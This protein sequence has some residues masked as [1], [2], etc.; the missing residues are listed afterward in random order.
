MRGKQMG[1]AEPSSSTVT[2]SSSGAFYSN[3]CWTGAHMRG[4]RME[5]KASSIPHPGG[6]EADDR[7][8]DQP[9]CLPPEPGST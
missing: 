2:S 8:R 6:P 9:H 5:G 1:G 7:I 4:Q 3:G